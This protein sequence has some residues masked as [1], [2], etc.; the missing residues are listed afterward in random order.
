MSSVFILL[1]SAILFPGLVKR[2]CDTNIDSATHSHFGKKPREAGS[3]LKPQLRVAL[4]S[5][6]YKTANTSIG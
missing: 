2:N 4:L 5:P 3:V 1:G 6:Q